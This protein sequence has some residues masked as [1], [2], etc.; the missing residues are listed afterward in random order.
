MRY[1]RLASPHKR[2]YIIFQ[3]V[4]EKILIYQREDFV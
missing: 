4:D 2:N 1:Q 3:T